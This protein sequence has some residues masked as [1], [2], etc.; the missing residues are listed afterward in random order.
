MATHPKALKAPTGQ[1]TLLS[2]AL[3]DQ[4]VQASRLS[5]R[6]RI[7]LPLHKGPEAPLHRMLNAIQPQSYIRPHRHLYPPKPET[8]I[9]L[10]GAIL[11]IVFTPSGE[12][13]EELTIA[14]GTDNFGFD[15]EPGVYHTFLALSIDTVIFEV[16]PGPYEVSTD[17]DFATW[18]PPEESPEAANYLAF[19]YKLREGD[20]RPNPPGRPKR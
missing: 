7:L 16:K 17:K 14:A 10:R 3:I 4:V 1:T 2:A 8:I 11:C 6:K 12:V 19:L 15:C 20:E 5:P 13:Q 18:A 9:V